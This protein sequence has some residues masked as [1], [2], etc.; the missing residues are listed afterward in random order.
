M[1]FEKFTE[2]A[3]GFI[4]SAQGLALRSNHQL[5]TPEHVLKVLLYDE[6][7]TASSLIKAAGGRSRSV[8]WTTASA[9]PASPAARRSCAERSRARKWIAHASVAGIRR[10]ERRLDAPGALP[11][12]PAAGHSERRASRAGRSG[13]SRRALVVLRGVGIAD[14]PSGPREGGQRDDEPQIFGQD[15]HKCLAARAQ[16]F[17]T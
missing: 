3:R 15:D 5:L 1:D 7:G 8:S 2:R 10:L 6:E 16:C 13:G 11:G 14:Q 9:K 12:R 17:A 4:Q